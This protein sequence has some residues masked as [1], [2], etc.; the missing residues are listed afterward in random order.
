MLDTDK[1]KVLTE[2]R[3]RIANQPRH[4]QGT[5]TDGHGSFCTLGS[6]FLATGNMTKECNFTGSEGTA[7]KYLGVSESD[8]CAFNNSHTREQ[9][10][11]MLDDKI[12]AAKLQ[13]V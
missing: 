6:L 7:Q 2:T 9:V 8:V 5:I 12:K 3:N 4:V 1:V 10:V 13:S 11:A